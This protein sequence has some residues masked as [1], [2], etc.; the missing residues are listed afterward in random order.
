[1][2]NSGLINFSDARS[3]SPSA[4]NA[5]RDIRRMIS[6]AF[7]DDEFFQQIGHHLMDPGLAGNR[8]MDQALVAEAVFNKVPVL[9]SYEN[10]N[11]K[12]LWA[13]ITHVLNSYG[14][15]LR[16]GRVAGH[17]LEYKVNVEEPDAGQ[18]A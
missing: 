10:L 6:E 12:A 8:Q 9:R 14:Y 1:M 11:H 3:L 5:T 16:G 13:H 4:T 15:D 2:T 7:M 17:H 18:A